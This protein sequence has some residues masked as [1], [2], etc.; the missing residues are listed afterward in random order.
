MALAS[1]S[2]S[3]GWIVGPAIGG[4]LLQ[5][6]PLALWPAAAGACLVAGLGAIAPEPRR[7]VRD[8]E[9]DHVA[10][11][12]APRR[13]RLREAVRTEVEGGAAGEHQDGV[14]RLGV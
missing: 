8:G 12:R 14:R 9:V 5:H 13:D 7:G 10:P 11:G 2:W 4:Y 1:N 6:A 3:I